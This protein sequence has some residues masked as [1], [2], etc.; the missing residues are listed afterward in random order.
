[1]ADSQD[2]QQFT[3]LEAV[4]NTKLDDVLN[5]S[6]ENN[7]QVVIES[8][9]GKS[10]EAINCNVTTTNNSNP[11]NINKSSNV[12]LLDEYDPQQ[13]DLDNLQDT[14]DVDA[15]IDLDSKD[16]TYDPAED[17]GDMAGFGF[18]ENE[19]LGEI[20]NAKEMENFDA[21]GTPSKRAKTSYG[22]GVLSGK[23][24]GRPLGSLNSNSV[25]RVSKSQYVPM[26][27]GMPQTPGTPANTNQGQGTP[28][29]F[30]M[31]TKSYNATTPKESS[32]KLY[33]KVLAESSFLEQQHKNQKVNGKIQIVKRVNLTT[34]KVSDV[35]NE[36]AQ[37]LREKSIASYG[38]NGNEGKASITGLLG[39]KTIGRT[40]VI[41]KRSSNGTPIVNGT[42]KT[43]G[44]LSKGLKIGRQAKIN[45]PNIHVAATI[46]QE[47][48]VGSS[49]TLNRPRIAGM[50]TKTGETIVQMSKFSKDQDEA[51][52]QLEPNPAIK[53]V[54]V[55]PRFARVNEE[56]SLRL[57]KSFE[58][59]SGE[60]N[61]DNGEGPSESGVERLTL[62]E[63]FELIIKSIKNKDL[64]HLDL[65][66]KI[67][68]DEELLYIVAAKPTVAKDHCC[69][70][71]AI[72]CNDTLILEKVLSMF[73]KAQE[74]LKDLDLGEQ[75]R[76]MNEKISKSNTN[77]NYSEFKT[78]KESSATKQFCIQIVYSNKKSKIFKIL[79]D[80][81]TASLLKNTVVSKP[82]DLFGKHFIDNIARYVCKTGVSIEI[83]KVLLEKF[84]EVFIDKNELEKSEKTLPLKTPSEIENSSNHTTTMNTPL[85]HQ[86]IKKER[87]NS[88]DNVFEKSNTNEASKNRNANVFS[89]ESY[90]RTSIF[91]SIW[92][93]LQSGH[94]KIATFL[95][96]TAQAE[97]E[98]C[99]LTELMVHQ[100]NQ[101]SNLENSKNEEFYETFEFKAIH[102]LHQHEFRKRDGNNNRLSLAH[103]LASV[104]NEFGKK[105]FSVVCEKISD[106]HTIV[107]TT[108]RR[109]IHYAC[110][111]DNVE[112]LKFLMEE[113]RL[114]DDQDHYG[115]CGLMVAASNGAVKCVEFLL[116]NF[117]ETGF[118][119]YKAIEKGPYHNEIL[120]AVTAIDRQNFSSIH[121]AAENGRA[122][123]I[124]K[125]NEMAGF[126]LKN[127]IDK[128]I[129][130]KFQKMSPLMLATRNGHLESCQVLLEI[131]AK[132]EYVD[133]SD[134]TP[135]IHA[136]INGQYPCL[137]LFLR[138]GANPN[139]QDIYKNSALHYAVTHGHYHCVELLLQS[140]A[141]PDSMNVLQLSPLALAIL[142]HDQKMVEM[143]LANGADL[144]Y[145]L[146]PAATN[147][148]N[149]S[150]RSQNI[151]NL[152]G[153]TTLMSF[154][155]AITRTTISRYENEENLQMLMKALNLLLD[156]GDPNSQLS[157]D[158]KATHCVPI[159]LN[160]QD[161]FGYTCLHYLTKATKK[162]DTLHK[163]LQMM[164][165][166]GC[167]CN[168]MDHT[169]ATP[170]WYSVKN[171]N[172]SQLEVLSPKS[173][174]IQKIDDKGN[175]IL[176]L[177]IDSIEF[178]KE[179]NIDA[180]NAC[181]ID[182]LEESIDELNSQ[183][184]DPIEGKTPNQ[185]IE[186][187][188]RNIASNQTDEN[189]KNLVGSSSNKSN[190]TPILLFTLKMLEKH[191]DNIQ[192]EGH[193]PSQIY[194]NETTE[195]RQNWHK[196]VQNLQQKG[197]ASAGGANTHKF[198]SFL[199]KIFRTLM[200]YGQCNLDDTF[201]DS[202]QNFLHSLAK[203][204]GSGRKFLS[205]MLSVCLTC[206]V[207]KYSEL[208]KFGL[209]PLTMAIV[210][211]NIEFLEILLNNESGDA[212]C[213]SGMNLELVS[214]GKSMR[215]R[216][217]LDPLLLVVMKHLSNPF[218]VQDKSSSAEKK[219]NGDLTNIMELM[220]AK[221]SL[222]KVSPCSITGK[223]P[224][225]AAAEANVSAD[226]LKTL[227]HKARKLDQSKIIQ[228][229]ETD[230]M[231]VLSPILEP[232]DLIRLQ[233]NQ[234]RTALHL[235]VCNV[236]IRE[237]EEVGRQEASDANNCCELS[238]ITECVEILLENDIVNIGMTD[239]SGRTPLHYAFSEKN[240]DPLN[241]VCLLLDKMTISQIRQVD[242]QGRTALH[243][244]ALIGASK[245]LTLML[246]TPGVEE[247]LELKD[248]SG[249]T[250]LA[251]AIQNSNFETA[252]LLILRGCNADITIPKKSIDLNNIKNLGSGVKLVGRGRRTV[253][254]WNDSGKEL[255]EASSEGVQPH[256]ISVLFDM[257]N[258]NLLVAIINQKRNQLSLQKKIIQIA[259]A[260]RQFECTLWLVRRFIMIS[261]LPENTLLTSAE[262]GK[263]IVHT[264]ASAIPINNYDSSIICKL[265]SVLNDKCDL[266]LPAANG[267]TVVHYAVANRSL[268]ILQRLHS[269]FGRQKL[270]EIV[271]LN[272]PSVLAS[273]IWERKEGTEEDEQNC[274]DIL[275]FLFEIIKD[276]QPALTN[277]LNCSV[278]LPYWFGQVTD[279]GK[280]PDFIPFIETEKIDLDNRLEGMCPE[281]EAGIKIP[282]IHLFIRANLN[283]VLEMLLS[284]GMDPNACDATTG[285]LT[286]LM[287]AVKCNNFTALTKLIKFNPDINA[288]DTEH[289]SALH[290]SVWPLSWG[291]WKNTRTINFLLE[292]N[293]D[294]FHEDLFGRSVVDYVFEKSSL[295]VANFLNNRLTS[296]GS[297]PDKTN[298]LIPTQVY[299]EINGETS[300]P[301]P[302]FIHDAQNLYEALISQQTQ[303]TRLQ[304]NQRPAPTTNVLGEIRPEIDPIVKLTGNVMEDQ[305]NRRWAD[306]VLTGII[307]YS[308]DTP[309]SKL[310]GVPVTISSI[311]P[312]Q[313]MIRLQVVE[314][315]KDLSRDNMDNS[316]KTKIEA[317]L[318]EDMT[319]DIKSISPLPV[320]GAVTPSTPT[321]TSQCVYTL[322]ERQ[323]DNLNKP[324]NTDK[325]KLRDF[326]CNYASKHSVAKNAM[327]LF[328]NKYKQ[329]TSTEWT[330]LSLESQQKRIGKKMMVVPPELISETYG[331]KEPIKLQFNNKSESTIPNLHS[332]IMDMFNI[333]AIEELL[334]ELT[335]LDMGK[336]HFTR[337]NEANLLKA[338]SLVE[339]LNDTLTAINHLNNSRMFDLNHVHWLYEEALC[340]MLSV[341]QLIPLRKSKRSENKNDICRNAV[342]AIFKE[343]YA[344][345]LAESIKTI[346]KVKTITEIMLGA[347]QQR[348]SWNWLDYCYRSLN[349]TIKLLDRHSPETR[350]ILSQINPEKSKVLAIYKIQR[351]GEAAQFAK[352]P[353]ASMG[354]KNNL[355]LWRASNN[356]E[357]VDTLVNGS[358]RLFSIEADH[359]NKDPNSNEEAKFART[360]GT[361]FY[362][363]FEDA[364]N[365]C[366][367][368]KFS[369][370]IAFYSQ[371]ILG[372]SK[373][374]NLSNAKLES[375]DDVE[376]NSIHILGKNW[377]CDDGEDSD[378]D[379]LITSEGGE[380][381]LRQPVRREGIDKTDL[382]VTPE[383][384][385]YIIFDSDQVVIRYAV[386]FE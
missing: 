253:N 179:R 71:L 88:G 3:V 18:G 269:L 17:F 313:T 358:V 73:K 325:I 312:V 171:K 166:N 69:L 345:K 267:L 194:Y 123:V 193:D 242:Q 290:H 30:Q 164:L 175:N 82:H 263:T 95:A 271:K 131:G 29:T 115:R 211:R 68:T 268:Q 135:L 25:H 222:D 379:F 16:P 20:E 314:K 372:K 217:E 266:S 334:P 247:D 200:I 245:C 364:K 320:S 185:I 373:V 366:T 59:L 323:S 186:K 7:G 152:S 163:L 273:L 189:L 98:N 224:L 128:P 27:P 359:N 213:K 181:S 250:V 77:T 109:P 209:T 28:G 237:R 199:P 336:L 111:V 319:D 258:R 54:S 64:E 360:R 67:L 286:P 346:V 215:L 112:V 134:R 44:L 168:F 188:I 13:A 36:H 321:A 157:I 227:L 386:R 57:K 150:Q 374:C 357:C 43:T 337:L 291:M 86:F 197:R 39:K 307:L 159:D 81:P 262:E 287:T 53:V 60:E 2:D 330:C 58:T 299:H 40:A 119:T 49:S 355:L 148:G 310:D 97:S 93:A 158:R 37:K 51:D 349:T 298:I 169:G 161:T 219:I 376:Y 205:D 103:I 55:D 24:P 85:N 288:T 356:L 21:V 368:S 70:H 183:D 210:Y 4:S 228:K 174:L 33:N 383:N 231:V 260:R 324:Y 234:G 38:K 79:Q 327:T 182:S 114:K 106:F 126:C 243:I 78:V 177:L 281:H 42:A 180:I 94:F 216:Y 12:Q 264:I 301:V 279:I 259:L 132:V 332:L 176:H 207:V 162:S 302:D 8:G 214:S 144:N 322:I 367:F 136:A 46:K 138:E 208:D 363:N 5:N 232:I 295:Q 285:N 276:D 341:R 204:T 80:N 370:K 329:H 192:L 220:L 122:N 365:S 87:A 32:Q 165:D 45:T 116:Q 11:I 155:L 328:I 241:L 218:P 308:N 130:S 22:K 361:K 261:K 74:V 254:Y 351:E 147:P 160:V 120:L 201:P 91:K 246:Q 362:Q 223:T 52:S 282:I 104:D 167:D 317:V 239:R 173:R 275:D 240:I 315:E 284:Y 292:H 15:S 66:S 252:A 178:T 289:R 56:E 129:A 34:G 107:D 311:R 142:N 6:N 251:L 108:G 133:L 139:K 99:T 384:D 124:K 127:W 296:Q 62:Q 331:F 347:V 297:A 47:L 229:T 190:L 83:I 236:A 96:E 378:K 283:K 26:S 102:E 335:D 235:A 196:F 270:A 72:D 338:Q 14:I 92:Y 339:K 110:S 156:Y 61:M 343:S 113:K 100:L 125:L 195:D 121:F 274:L 249:A 304:N 256:L 318:N 153:R 340:H 76:E 141:Y 377:H 278:P 198:D 187:T 50:I 354:N 172:L 305:A 309:L 333:S 31:R 48:G 41:S 233:D 184:A 75:E 293:I 63:K 248:K 146:L 300:L 191:I 280:V 149:N 23:K 212:K 170:I 105:C 151:L 230:E 101:F 272:Q 277:F 385:E 303:N 244:A 143:L 10:S 137:S 90:F 352:C 145:R 203:M 221:K 342:Q 19:D 257:E 350:A 140:G 306:C 380:I 316:I 294:T 117:L 226:M 326:N 371:V 375:K 382:E 89:K 154:I 206:D 348:S 344:E 238:D 84:P 202:R 381:P 65:A 9:I 118:T 353:V 369:K 225:I 1:M 35:S 255:Q 265:L